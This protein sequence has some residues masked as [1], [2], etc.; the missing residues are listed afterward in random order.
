MEMRDIGSTSSASFG[1]EITGVIV[2]PAVAMQSRQM[3]WW[4]ES[5]LYFPVI[6]EISDSKDAPFS[7]WNMKQ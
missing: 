4:W 5:H 6:P 7:N 1:R 3:Q 2:L